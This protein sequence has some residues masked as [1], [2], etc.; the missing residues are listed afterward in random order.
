MSDAIDGLEA[1]GA[2][3][4]ELSAA[5]DWPALLEQSTAVS[6]RWPDA[7]QPAFHAGRALLET[8]AYED[9]D[10]HLLLCM[11][12]FPTMAQ[13]AALY[14]QV[15]SR[16]LSRT[17]ALARWQTIQSRLPDAAGMKVG[18]A[19]AY[20]AASELD[21]AEQ[22][23]VEGLARWPRNT[24]LLVLSAEL[25]AQRGDWAEAV[26]R[27]TSARERWPDRVDLL[28]ANVG[29]LRE[30]GRVA[31]AETLARHG[32]DRFPN[33]P[34]VNTSLA[35]VAA[36]K[37]DWP[38]VVERLRRVLAATPD[39][40]PAAVGLVGALGR[41]NRPDE[42]EAAAQAALHLHPDNELL[43]VEFATLASRAERW[44]DAVDRWRQVYER[45]PPREAFYLQ[46]VAALEAADR[47]VDADE[48]ANEAVGFAP[49]DLP[50]LLQHA[51]L[52][53]R[54]FDVMAAKQRWGKL[55]RRFP[56]HEEVVSG[57][58]AAQVSMRAEAR[59]SLMDEAAGSHAVVRGT[60]RPLK[61]PS[62]PERDT[63]PQVGATALDLLLT[64]APAGP[65]AL[66]P[67]PLPPSG[68]SALIRRLF[69]RGTHG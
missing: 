12:R 54:R 55:A 40:L 11:D 63:L 69:G 62:G 2:K 6:R 66:P 52:A 64:G 19:H 26:R 16:A 9:A 56:D 27:W 49:D 68:F 42:A 14:C 38:E 65:L 31:E 20:R 15:G 4:D 44:N 60:M 8:G 45:C 43:L 3:L 32:L 35:A 5:G 58:A 10:H 22:A 39:S 23:A 17:D 46:Y 36:A 48:V 13:F 25:A 51:R 53:E 37:Q 41:L 50:L 29:A 61:R 21:H 24:A 1:R 57:A 67:R 34:E 47:L 28:V 7:W 18:L 59:Q 30:S 33:H